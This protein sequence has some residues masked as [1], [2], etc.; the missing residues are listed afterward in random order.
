MRMM[1]MRCLQ[2]K[3][4]ASVVD[5]LMIKSRVKRASH[6]AMST[7]TK[8]SNNRVAKIRKNKF[9]PVVVRANAGLSANLQRAGTLT[10]DQQKFDENLMLGLFKL[11]AARSVVLV[12]VVISVSILR[13]LMEDDVMYLEI[14]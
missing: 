3:F 13:H 12:F 6:L 14:N 9:K 7:N 8:K 11:E 1:M 4:L 5:L 2:R 10:S